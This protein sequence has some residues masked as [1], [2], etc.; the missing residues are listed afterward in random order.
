MLEFAGK[1]GWKIQKRDEAEITNFCNQIGVE[2]GVLKV[3]MHNNKSTLG[4]NENYGSN[5]K[6]SNNNNGNENENSSSGSEDKMEEQHKNH[7]H[8]GG[9]NAANGN[10]GSSSSS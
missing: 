10:H 9:V 2:R 6:M 7:D 8:D 4:K 3:W 5:K 1:V